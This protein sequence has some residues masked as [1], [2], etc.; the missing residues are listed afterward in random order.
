VD[1]IRNVVLL[2][3]GFVQRIH[4]DKVH[5]ERAVVYQDGRFNFR[6]VGQPGIASI[7]WSDSTSARST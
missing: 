1:F 3:F 4:A 6:Y 2:Q 5:V 7:E